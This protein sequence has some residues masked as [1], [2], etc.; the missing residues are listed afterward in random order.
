MFTFV[1][2]LNRSAFEHW[3][4]LKISV[5]WVEKHIIFVTVI[6]ESNIKMKHQISRNLFWQQ[7]EFISLLYTHYTLII[8]VVEA[9]TSNF[10]NS[11][12]LSVNLQAQFAVLLPDFCNYGC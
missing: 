10:Y 3:A 1:L 6:G 11:I 9:F 4:L 5:I 12:C 2:K 8:T 7:Q